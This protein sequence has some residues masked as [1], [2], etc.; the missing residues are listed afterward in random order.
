MQAI[1][2]ARVQGAFNLV[3]G[4]WPLIHMR[5]FEAVLG[6]KRDRWLARHKNVHFHFTPTH[7]SWLNQIEIWFSILAR[8]TLKR[9]SFASVRQLRQAIDAFIEAYNPTATPF[10][11]QK[12]EV[13]PKGLASRITDL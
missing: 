1:T 8:S 10:Q 13:Q 12:A 5:S 7:A 3:N 9:A 6:P 2:L 4:L 11:W